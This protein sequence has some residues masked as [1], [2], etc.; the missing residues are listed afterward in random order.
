ML[1]NCLFY[2]IQVVSRIQQG[3]Q[4]RGNHFLEWGREPT[5]IRVY[6][7]LRHE[8]PP[9]AMTGLI[10]LLSLFELPIY[11]NNNNKIGNKILLSYFN[12]SNTIFTVAT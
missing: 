7:P 1:M 10:F 12:M 6:S 8:W 11:T 5:T 4:P 2:E 3:R 9:C